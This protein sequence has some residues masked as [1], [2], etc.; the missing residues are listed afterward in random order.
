MKKAIIAILLLSALIVG[1]FLYLYVTPWGLKPPELKVVE[2]VPVD[3]AFYNST[4]EKHG[5][6]ESV[7]PLKNPLPVFKDGA[8]LCFEVRVMLGEKLPQKQSRPDIPL[9]WE[10]GLILVT[11]KSISASPQG[12][13]RGYGVWMCTFPEAGTLRVSF[14]YDGTYFGKKGG[15]D[16]Y[17]QNI[18]LPEGPFRLEHLS[19]HGFRSVSQQFKGFSV[20]HLIINNENCFNYTKVEILSIKY[21]K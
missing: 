10:A 13:V 12:D 4:I 2:T 20:T 17:R 3:Y 16:A 15:Y 6:W 9:E 19:L 18:P 14:D 5:K 21:E 11:D 1:I 7:Y 8:I